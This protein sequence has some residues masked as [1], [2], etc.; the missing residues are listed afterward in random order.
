M[1]EKSEGSKPITAGTIYHA[2]ILGLLGLCLGNVLLNLLVFR[3]PRKVTKSS[4]PETDR[5]RISV[6]VPARNEERKLGACLGSLNAQTARGLEVI[7]LDDDSL[8]RTYAVA[9]EHGFRGEANHAV[10]EPL[11][12]AGSQDLDAGRRR[13]LSGQPLPGGWIGKNWAC[14][15]LAQAARG[16]WLVFTDADTIHEPECIASA[17]AHAERTGAD[18]LSLWPR[19]IT[20]TWSER[21]VVP[22][23]YLLILGFL[24]QWMG[25]LAQR[26]PWLAGW[27]PPGGLKALGAANG[28]FI[29]IRREHYYAIGGHYG[30]RSEL[31]EDLVLGQR[32]MAGAAHGRRLVNADGTQLLSCRMYEGF[33]DLWEGFSKNLRPAFEDKTGA[34]IAFGLSQFMGFVLPFIWLLWPGAWGRKYRPFAAAQVG[35]IYLMRAL[36]AIIYG[37]GRLS[38]L[39]HPFGHSLTLLIGCNSWRLFNTKGVTWKGR[40]YK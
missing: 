13:L 11:L 33:P 31:V 34:F 2:F 3:R 32:T 17:I 22:L 37:S 21:L 23:G 8:D 28:Q 19:Q 18:L 26:L 25:W 24:P 29:L 20:K 9:L 5:I 27:L 6:L 1:R 12:G 4:E 39:L 14:W 10:A 15:Q 38:A 7:T 36:F 35:L 40:V 16:D 30:V